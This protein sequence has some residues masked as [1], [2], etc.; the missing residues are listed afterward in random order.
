[1][2]VLV[3]A[4]PLVVAHGSRQKIVLPSVR[5]SYSEQLCSSLNMQWGK[6]EIFGS[7]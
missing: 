3:E 7:P 1:M 6:R 5:S 2:E 4:T